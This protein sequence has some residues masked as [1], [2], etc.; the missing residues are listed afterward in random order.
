MKEEF[1]VSG[2][3][4]WGTVTD[5]AAI[6]EKFDIGILIFADNLQNEGTQ[7]LV[8]VDAMRGDYAY[9][10]ALWWDDPV[11]F[12]L[13]QYRECESMPWRSFWSASDMPQSLRAHYV[14]CNRAAPVG[15]ARRVGLR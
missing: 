15:S 4:H 10:I 8:N 12:R 13:A 1:E 14:V 3:H 7:C 2:N 6:S 11:H 9:F 5:C